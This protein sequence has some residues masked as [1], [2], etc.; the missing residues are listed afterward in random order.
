VIGEQQQPSGPGAS[1][2]SKG[3]AIAGMPHSAKVTR[4][5]IAGPET[6]R[7]RVAHPI[8]HR[9]AEIG[10]PRCATATSQG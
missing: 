4:C 10:G 3:E 2:L 8:V 1:H 9:P 6:R 7:L 5:R